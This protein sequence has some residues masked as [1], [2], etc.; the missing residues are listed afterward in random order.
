L[1]QC[2]GF[3]QFPTGVAANAREPEAAKAF[4]AYVMSPDGATAIKA[5]GM[6]PG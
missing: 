5:R 4:I 3:Y 2:G 6:T 1:R